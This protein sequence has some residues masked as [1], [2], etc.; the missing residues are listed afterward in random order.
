MHYF[1]NFLEGPSGALRATTK[2]VVNFLEEKLH[3][4]EN[5]GNAYE[6]AHPQKKSFRCL[7]LSCC[8][9]RLLTEI[10]RS[11]PVERVFSHEVLFMRPTGCDMMLSKCNK[12][13]VK[14][15]TGNCQ[16][17]FAVTSYTVAAVKPLMS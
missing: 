7:C 11:A 9:K 5:P 17:C 15:C 8:Q 13:L 1:R 12:H 2:N 3:P 6:F 4:R 10:R 14:N 16:C